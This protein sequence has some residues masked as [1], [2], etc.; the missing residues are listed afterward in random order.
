MNYEIVNLE[1]KIIVGVSAI[2]SNED[3]KMEKVIGGLWEKLYQDGINKIIKNK[4][5][6]N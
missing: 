2:T 4:V 1:E 3:P 5:N 6:E